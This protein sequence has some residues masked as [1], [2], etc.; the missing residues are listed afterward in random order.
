M[1][2]N[3]KAWNTLTRMPYWRERKEEWNLLEDLE[4]EL[5]YSRIMFSVNLR[6]KQ[7]EETF[8]IETRPDVFISHSYGVWIKS[9]RFQFI[10]F[11]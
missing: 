4:K 5:S 2:G 8:F 11:K 1:D 10:Y 6:M 7:V 3:K 9:I